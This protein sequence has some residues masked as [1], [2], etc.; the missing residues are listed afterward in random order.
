MVKIFP[1]KGITYN[2]EKISNLSK[3]M[4]PPYDVIS[5]EEQDQLYAQHD[6]NVIRLILGKD[7]P[8]DTKYNNK[9]V[10]AAKYLEGFLLHR[11]LVQ[12]DK[13]CLY[14]YEQTFGHNQKKYKRLGLFSLLRLEDFG[15]GKV[16][17]HE[18]TFPKAKIDRLEILRHTYAHLESVFSIFSDSKLKFT[19]LLKKLAKGRP[20]IKVKGKNKIE[21]KI[22]KVESK[23]AIKKILNEMKDKW[24]FIA[25]GHHRYEAALRFKDEV[26]EKTQRFS[27]E[28]PYNYILMYFTPIEDKGLLVL[29]IHRVVRVPSDTFDPIQFEGSLYNHFDVKVFPFKKANEKRVRARLLKELA[30]HRGTKHAFGIYLG[31]N[32]Y[33]LATLKDEKL[34]EEIITENK[35][36]AWKKLDVPILHAFIIDLLLGIKRGSPEAESNIKYIKNEEEGINLVNSKKYQAAIFLNPTS[37]NDIVQIAGKY[38]KMPQKSTFFYPKLLS[39]MVMYKIDLKEKIKE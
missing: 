30:K 16:F 39:G 14:I 19:K 26:K 38:E 4:A 21:H 34:I 24:A 17:P 31:G 12:N 10:R 29:P 9:Y 22:W 33:L 35:P 13:P 20:L 27:E 2:T 37:V 8:E 25:D 3:V 18:E 7:F 28:E 32:K 15:K 6:Y 5:P 11:I 36:K 23:P 1:F